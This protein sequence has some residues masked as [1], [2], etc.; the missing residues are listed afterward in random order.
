MKTLIII[1]AYNEQDSIKNVVDNLI[2]NYPAYDYVIINDCSTDRTAAICAENGYNVLHLPCNL[3]IGGG[4]QTGY[5]Y[6]LEN[7]YDIAVQMDGDGQHDPAFLDELT[8][9]LKSGEAD[10]CIGSRFI[11]KE[12]F[13]SSGMR[14]LGI[15]FL[16]ALIR[17]CCGAK[18]KDVTSGY[19]AVNRKLIEE[20]AQNYADDYPEPEAI[21]DAKLCGA[22]IVEVPVVMKS[23]EGGESSISPIRSVYYMIKVSL[24]VLFYRI[25]VSGRTRK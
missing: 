3:G 25:V 6:A 20:Y 14:R 16:S 11:T 1:P 5:K 12:G 13:Q 7:G 17:L 18:V 8:R 2:V 4:V 10:V 9:M 24:A 19:R 23:R 15:S 21:V 22:R